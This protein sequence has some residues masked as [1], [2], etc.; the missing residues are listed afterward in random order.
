MFFKETR[1]VH[2][3]LRLTKQR[4]TCSLLVLFQPTCEMGLASG[5]RSLLY[6]L[7]RLKI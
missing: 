2:F 1:V 4:N 6:S 7:S 5:V 3:V